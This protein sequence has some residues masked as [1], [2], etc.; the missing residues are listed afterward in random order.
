MSL[1]ARQKATCAA[2]ERVEG[3]W[4]SIPLRMIDGGPVGSPQAYGD[5]A[6]EALVAW[7]AGGDRRAFHEIVARHGPF[8]LRVARRLLSDWLAAEDVVQDAMVRAW[9]QA[10][11]FDPA[12]A[13]FRTWLYRIV[14]NLC[15]DQR[16]RI[17]PESLPDDLEFVDP[18][19]GPDETLAA[20]QWDVALAAALGE[21]PVRERAA[22]T[23]VYDEGL[24]A[25]E[26]AR[27]L[28]A[29]AKAVER[30]LARAR[31]RLRER[32]QAVSQ[33]RESR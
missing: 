7:S 33:E 2:L 27:I 1:E 20:R 11:R 29:S 24:S 4:P 28:G 15:L 21:L 30:L 12:R 6:D 18:A 26:A 19:P 5:A 32:M 22:M 14:V 13:R 8:A 9:S 31:A 16:R 10:S 25:A 17:Q 3:A 23:L